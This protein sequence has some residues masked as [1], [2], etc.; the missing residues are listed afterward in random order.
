MS[1]TATSPR[2]VYS[3]YFADPFVWEHGGEYFAIGTGEREASGYPSEM[4]FPLLRSK[5][6]LNWRRASRALLRPDP[7]LGMNFWAPEVAFADGKFWLYYSVGFGDKQHQLR[8]AMSDTPLGP[9][10][11]YDHALIDLNSCP[12]AIDAHPFQDDDGQWYLFYAR[13]FLDSSRDLRPGTALMVA[14]MKSMTELDGAGEVVLRARRDWQR[15][16]RDRAMY[17]LTYDWHTLEGPFVRKREGRYYCLY[18]AGRWENDTYG[19]DYGVADNVMGPYSDDGNE[20]GPRV[21]RTVHGEL[22][23]PG[24]NSVVRGPDG[25]DYI[26]YHAWDPQMTARRMFIER[27][28]WTGDGPRCERL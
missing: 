27:L 12:F 21:L 7:A 3:E 10:Q 17:G 22:I 13:D 11:D 28:N 16:E 4:V 25:S 19:V 15:F 8:V 24:H 26:V 6:L 1:A 9:Y 5:D 23:G 2:P 18:S 14:R 20:G